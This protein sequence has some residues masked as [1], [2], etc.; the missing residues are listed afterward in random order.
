MK[1]KFLFLVFL[2]PNFIF[3]QGIWTKKSDFPSSSRNNAVSFSTGG[4]GYYGLGQK[5]TDI[6][7]FKVYTDFWEYDPEKDTWTQKTDF[8]ADGRLGAKGFAL[9]GK[10]YAGFGYIIEAFGPSA[11]GN[12]Y[13]PDF[14]EF[15]PDSNKWF[16]KNDNFLADRDICFNHNDTV[17][18]LNTNYKLLKKYIS[19]AD[20]W[21]EYKLEKKAFS[22]YYAEII[23][24]DADFSLDGKEYILTRIGRKKD[25]TNQLWEFNPHSLD[26]V[27]KNNLPPPANDTL[28]SFG[29]GEKIFALRGKNNLL[30]YNSSSDSWTDRTGTLPQKYVSPLF[31][32]NGKYY[33]IS[34]HEVWEFAP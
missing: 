29:I 24:S 30:E 21:S 19:S 3:S 4:K 32:L 31:P 11:G 17:W 7:K 34:Q 9:N 26:W 1:I 14:Y 33:F 16:R 25:A 12:H 20:S 27:L 23:G 10:G 22:P 28:I 5:Q 6:Y 15:I 8:P 2:L 13:L 18:S